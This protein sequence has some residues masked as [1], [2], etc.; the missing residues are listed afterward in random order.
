MTI[1]YRILHAVQL[2][3]SVIT[4]TPT[5]LA[6]FTYDYSTLQFFRS[7]NSSHTCKEEDLWPTASATRASLALCL[8]TGLPL[9]V[10]RVSQEEC[11]KLRENV[12][13]VKV[14]RYPKLNG[15]GDNGQRKVWSSCG[16]TYCTCSADTSPVP[17]ACPSLS[18]IAANFATAL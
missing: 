8:E 9:H 2:L 13:C 16:P 3:P 11:A 6:A 1:I 14:Y 12:P 17:C 7:L 10:Y 4:P 15:Y 18:F 5:Y